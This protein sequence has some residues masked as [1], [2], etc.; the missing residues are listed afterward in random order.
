MQLFARKM[1][2]MMLSENAWI[3]YEFGEEK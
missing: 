3:T 1:V 2:M